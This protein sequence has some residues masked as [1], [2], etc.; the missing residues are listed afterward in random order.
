MNTAPNEQNDYPG[1]QTA[2]LV[3][4]TQESAQLSETLRHFMPGV[5]VVE[6]DGI[7]IIRE[8]S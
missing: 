8:K 3:V 2:P 1:E 7:I 6:E 4:A 5:E